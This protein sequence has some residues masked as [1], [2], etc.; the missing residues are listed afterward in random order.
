M[1]IHFKIITSIVVF[2]MSISQSS[3]T[4]QKR[5]HDIFCHPI[6]AT[7]NVEKLLMEIAQSAVNIIGRLTQVEDHIVSDISI[8]S[9]SYNLHTR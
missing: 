7:L 3:V 2:V 1:L 8:D 4:E 5:K 6:G 9:Y